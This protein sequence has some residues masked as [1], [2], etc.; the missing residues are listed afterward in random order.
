MFIVV[1]KLACRINSFWTV[2]GAPVSSMPRPVAVP[3]GMPADTVA[4]L[5]RDTGLADVPLLDL[6]LVV[7]PAR[8]R[9]GKQPPLRRGEGPLL[10]QH[11]RLHQR[12]IERNGVP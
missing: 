3:K 4:D 10:V 11:Q 7:R 9:V 6:L 12:R 8:A 2:R 1:W 5:G